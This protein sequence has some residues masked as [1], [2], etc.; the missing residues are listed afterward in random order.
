MRKQLLVAL[1]FITRLSVGQTFTFT[2]RFS[3]DSLGKYNFRASSFYVSDTSKKVWMV[4]GKDLRGCT[5][6]KVIEWIGNPN[7]ID[8]LKDGRV[9]MNYTITKPYL[10][11]YLRIKENKVISV[12]DTIDKHDPVHSVK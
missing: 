9:Y 7:K 5:K 3:D 2:Q 10:Y 11:M 12:S 1:L 8:S 4:G 6:K